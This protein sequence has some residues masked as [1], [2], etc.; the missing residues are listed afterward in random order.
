MYSHQT[1]IDMQWRAPKSLVEP[2]WGF[3]YVELRKVGTWGP[4]PTS[5]TKRG[6]K[7]RAKSPRIRLGRDQ[8]I[9]SRTCIQ[10]QHKLVRTH[11]ARI[12]CWD[13]PRANSDSHD[14][15][16]PGLGRCHHHPPYSILC[17]TPPHPHPSGCLSWDSTLLSRFWIPR[18]LGHHSFSPDL[19][20]GRGLNQTCSP[21]RELFNAVSHSPSARRERVDS[22]LLVVRSQTVS[23]TP[24]PSFAHNLGCRCPNDRCKAISDIYTSRP[25]QWHQERPKPRCFSPFCQT[26]NIRESR[27]TPNPQLWECEFHPHT[28]PKWG[29][30]MQPV[31]SCRLFHLHELFPNCLGS[32]LL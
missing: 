12:W 22:R 14:T 28:W 29:C 18:T 8:A 24:G 1:V 32:I 15:P 21:L 27:R 11:S 30:D 7:G 2:T 6:V 20:L 5:S 9:W 23:L 13:K 31:H 4:L 10:N 17:V 3:N 26:L 25:F 19:Q 16:W